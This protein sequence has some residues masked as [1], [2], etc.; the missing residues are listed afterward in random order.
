MVTACV[1]SV[2]GIA[3]VPGVIGYR[4]FKEE[5][6]VAAVAAMLPEGAKAGGAFAM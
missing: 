4:V 2:L 6:R 3:A 1:A 5:G